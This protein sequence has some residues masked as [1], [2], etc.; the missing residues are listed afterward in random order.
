MEIEFYAELREN[1]QNCGNPG[2]Y[3]TTYNLFYRQRNK[4][5]S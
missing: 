4:T 3:Q 5:E 1:L 2:K